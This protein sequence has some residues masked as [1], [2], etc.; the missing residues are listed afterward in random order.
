M[1]QSVFGGLGGRREKCGIEHLGK[2][3]LG[4]VDGT[5]FSRMS[6]IYPEE[7]EEKSMKWVEE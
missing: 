1:I 4:R 7:P 2:V 5:G 6:R 3:S